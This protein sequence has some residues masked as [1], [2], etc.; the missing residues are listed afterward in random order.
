V[1]PS[2]VG[3]Y[4]ESLLGLEVKGQ[5]QG[6]TH[7]RFGFQKASCF[8]L[9]FEE[10]REAT[11]HLHCGEESYEVDQAVE[12]D[13]FAAS[14]FAVVAELQ[15]AGLGLQDRRQEVE[16]LGVAF[17]AWGPV[18]RCSSLACGEHW[19]LALELPSEVPWGLWV[20]FDQELQD[21]DQLQHLY[22]LV[23]HH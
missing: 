12:V 16:A 7:C 19:S 6:M 20:Y 22:H 13:H 10:S 21:F 5:L 1:G 17:L 8:R 2:W 23:W 18:E 4:E 3:S 9:A 11:F 15:G 14:R